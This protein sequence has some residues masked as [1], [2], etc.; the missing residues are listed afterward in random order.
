MEE[1]PIFEI[2]RVLGILAFRQPTCL[3]DSKTLKELVLQAGL[4]A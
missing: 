2:L 1:K 3:Q 4:D